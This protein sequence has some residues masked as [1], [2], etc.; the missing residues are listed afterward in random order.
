M[1]PLASTDVGAQAFA[2][3]GSLKAGLQHSRFAHLLSLKGLMF[4]S[5]NHE[6]TAGTRRFGITGTPK[7]DGPWDIA[8]Q[9]VD[10]TR[11]PV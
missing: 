11:L 4:P 9:L 5:Q 8:A 7:A 3:P 10:S 2:C 6:T 1:R